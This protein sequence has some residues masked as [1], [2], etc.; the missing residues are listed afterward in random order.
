MN[1]NDQQQDALFVNLVLVFKSAAMQQM[2]KIMHPLTGK[3]EKN[4]D[5]ARFSIDTLDMLKTKTQGNLSPELG[6]LL[7]S[8]LLELRMNYVEEVEAKEEAGEPEPEPED[9]ERSE[10]DKGPAGAE[11]GKEAAVPESET[12]AAETAPD[13]EGASVVGGSESAEGQSEP[14]EAGGTTPKKAKPRA[15]GKAKPKGRKRAKKD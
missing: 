6:K 5:Q 4:L 8:T 12:S 3:V 1:E 7:D 13:E 15:R 11:A 14:R 9:R 2:G 10:G